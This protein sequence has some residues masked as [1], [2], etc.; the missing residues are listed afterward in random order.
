MKRKLMVIGLDCAPPEIVLDRRRELPVLN[1]LIAAGRHGKMHSSH[2]PITIPAWMV[3]ATGKDPGRLGLY[4]FRHRRAYTYDKMWIANSLSIKEPAVWDILGDAGGRS[5]LVSVP[6]S[7][8]P[9]PVAGDLVGCFITPGADKA[10]TYPEGLKAEIESRFGPYPFDVVFRTDDRDAILKAIYDM[11]AKRFDILTWMAREKP[12]DLFWFV[13][14]GVDRIQHAFWKFHDPAHH[15]YEP[16]NKYERAILDYY[17]YLDGRI[18]ELLE[19]VPEE[20]AVLVVSDH[21]AKRMKGAFCV[22]EW[23]IRQG[24]LVLREAPKK[25]ANIE[26]TPI[27]WGRTKAWGWGGYYARIFLNV[28]GREPQGIIKPEDYEAEREA[29]AERLRGV[30]GPDGEAWATRVIKPNEFYPQ[31][32]GDYPDLMVY[33]DDLYW[34]SAGTLGWGT[35]YLAENDTGPDDAV[36][37]QDGMYILYDPADRTSR[38]QDVDILD[39]APTILAKLG[40]PVPT[41]MTGRAVD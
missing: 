18:G 3:M 16:G 30:R 26:K 25:G 32:R 4:G 33:F 20:A 34:R 29:L 23:L 6:P 39:L 21:G 22:N 14:I 24:D 13:E 11:T 1:R 27:D 2:P 38:R 8:P 9:H 40:L 36:H 37:A 17:K 31:L 28:E 7:Y 12:W 41:D 35:M 5:V 19:A 10:Y 15:L